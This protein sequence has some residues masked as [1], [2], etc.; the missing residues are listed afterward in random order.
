[1]RSTSPGLGTVMLSPNPSAA[2]RHP[3]KAADDRG[4]GETSYAEQADKQVDH[5]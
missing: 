4:D 1:M 3:T 2:L 5:G